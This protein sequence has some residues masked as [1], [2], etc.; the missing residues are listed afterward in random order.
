M[1]RQFQRI[2]R[3]S[4]LASGFCATLALANGIHLSVAQDELESRGSLPLRI[5]ADPDRPDPE[6]D[7]SLIAADGRLLG[8]AEGGVVRRAGDHWE[9]LAPAADRPLHLTLR[10]TTRDP[11]AESDETKITVLPGALKVLREALPLPTP[12][13]GQVLAYMG[14]PPGSVPTGRLPFHDIE[15]GERFEGGTGHGLEPGPFSVV[16]CGPACYDERMVGVDLGR[17]RLNV[18][19]VGYGRP[20]LV[21]LRPGAGEGSA[22]CSWEDPYAAPGARVTRCELGDAPMAALTLKGNVK[23]I[24][25]EDLRWEGKAWRSQGMQHRV[26]VCG[27]VPLAGAP[28][29]PGLVDGEGHQARCRS[30]LGMLHLSGGAKEGEVLFTQAGCHAIRRLDLDS[31]KVSTLYGDPREAGGKDGSGAE[32]RFHQP[33]R[34]VLA[35]DIEQGGRPMIYV[36]DR[37]NRCIRVVDPLRCN[38]RT[39]KVG[40]GV[41]L[42][43]PQGLAP[44]ADH[45]LVVV[46]RGDR[47]VKC[48][49]GPF[50]DVLVLAGHAPGQKQPPMDPRELTDPR[51]LATTNG[52]NGRPIYYFLDGHALVAMTLGSPLRWVAGSAEKAGFAD[53]PGAQAGVP[54]LNKP[55]DLVIVHVPGDPG[56]VVVIADTGN[57]ALRAYH[58]GTGAL[59]TLVGNPGGEP[60]RWG[61][62]RLGLEEWPRQAED[63][64]TLVAPMALTVLGVSEN[65]VLGT[66]ACLARLNGVCH[67]LGTEPWPGTGLSA[68]APT[69]P[70]TPPEAGRPWS[71]TFSVAYAPQPAV[72]ALPQPEPAAAPPEVPFQFDY[73]IT[74]TDREGEVPLQGR[75][76]FLEPIT[77]AAP[78]LS[79]GENPVRIR[80]VTLGGRS[81]ATRLTVTAVAGGNQEAPVELNR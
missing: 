69:L 11:R 62:A 39:L 10:V 45:S 81:M 74:C 27:L 4:L 31:G 51:G 60:Q 37:G 25:L 20:L 24:T 43:D 41:A 75:G 77:V 70:A 21:T 66:G 9:Y 76:R 44:G 61:L 28:E 52:R 8:P 2:G 33:G 7:F 73:Y 49:C 17:Y 30:A 29:A 36:T 59:T 80:C 47:T 54:C 34:L 50:F 65:L 23:S 14:D 72:R 19:A 18:A 35:P 71:L 67:R 78:A 15:R 5:Q 57:D 22:L 12:L 55:T 56:H 68:I 58:P 40:L 63:Y 6:V 1:S 26:N 3:A 53:L 42:V 13:L 64:A 38:V 48:I 16:R 46:D 32:A 79:A